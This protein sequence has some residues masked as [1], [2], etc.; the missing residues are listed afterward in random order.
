M[1]LAIDQGDRNPLPVEIC[2]LRIVQDR[3]LD[4]RLA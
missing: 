3:Q 1:W 4:E 2:K